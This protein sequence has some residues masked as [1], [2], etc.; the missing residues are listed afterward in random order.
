MEGPRTMTPLEALAQAGK[1]IHTHE[2]AEKLFVALVSNPE[3]YKYIAGLAEQSEQKTG[4][5]R[6]TPKYTQEELTQKNINKAYRM[7]EQF[8]AERL[9]REKESQ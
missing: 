5:L 7:A 8:M 9:R 1:Q 4:N 3:R 6:T 2:L